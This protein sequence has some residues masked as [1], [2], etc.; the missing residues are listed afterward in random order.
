MIT[1]KEFDNDTD[2]GAFLAV[3]RKMQREC[4]PDIPF[5]DR[6]VINNLSYCMFSERKFMNVFVAYRNA[7]II[8]IAVASASPY[9][10]S[11]LIGTTLH[12]WYVL[13]K[14]RGTRAAPELL[15]AF[16]KWSRFVSGYRMHLGADRVDGADAD[17]INLMIS[18][19]GFT[20]YGEQFYKVIGEAHG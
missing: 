2:V 14:Y 11:P 8:G 12:Y 7:E 10:F 13:P 3:A 20:R 18:K 19:R 9:Y 17:I 5:N 16:E 4:E 15:R 1:V 6:E